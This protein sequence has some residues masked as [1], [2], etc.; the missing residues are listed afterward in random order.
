[1][2]VST[3]RRVR[4]SGGLDRLHRLWM[5]AGLGVLIVAGAGLGIARGDEPEVT[6]RTRSISRGTE[7]ITTYM[8]R[9]YWIVETI[10]D[11]SSAKLVTV[12]KDITYENPSSGTSDVPWF[13]PKSPIWT[14]LK[15]AYSEHFKGRTQRDF[16]RL[17]WRDQLGRWHYESCQTTKEYEGVRYTYHTNETYI[18]SEDGRWR[19]TAGLDIEDV[20]GPH[21]H[22][23]YTEFNEGKESHDPVADTTDCANPEFP[24]GLLKGKP[25]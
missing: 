20:G 24:F 3:F 10:T 19:R 4:T 16:L 23:E 15:A 11:W 7:K 22:T 18:K 6:T 5:A 17:E 2:D 25:L 9:A 14:V 8:Y 12:N 21:P 1:M 13:I